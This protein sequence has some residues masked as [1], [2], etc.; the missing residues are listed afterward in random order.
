M[1]SPPVDP[2]LGP[3]EDINA[4]GGYEGAYRTC[5]CFWGSTPGSV[6]LQLDQVDRLENLD[7]LDVGCGE[8]KNAAWL[9]S[10]NC[11]VCAVDLSTTAIEHAR[12]S[13]PS[14]TVD[15]RVAD[16]T[17]FDWIQSQGYD[18]TI[19]YGLMHCLRDEVTVRGV[20]EGLK[21]STRV[22]G[23]SVLVAFNSGPH[24]LSAHP[25]FEPLLLSHEYYLAQ[26]SDWELEF[27]S[28]SLL[29]ETHP[30]NGIPHFHSMTRIA[31]RKPRD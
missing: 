23:R 1:Q 17:T 7:V 22:G 25:G 15:W 24:D 26:F 27:N 14:S 28:D 30:N 29:H 4:L 11:H 13:H 18:L 16:V 5:P 21:Q 8:G 20:I 2:H 31:A 9:A 19:A 3:D 12:A 10:R 6:L